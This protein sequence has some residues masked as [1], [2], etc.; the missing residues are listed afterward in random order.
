MKPGSTPSRRVLVVGVPLLAVAAL[1]MLAAGPTV[2]RWF[3][4]DEDLPK[5]NGVGDSK[6]DASTVPEVV[7]MELYVRRNLDDE[8]IESYDVVTEGEEQ[9]I[10]S[11]NPL[12]PED[13]LRLYAEFNQPSCWYLVQFDPAG[14]YAVLAKSHV[15]QTQ[16]QFPEQDRAGFNPDD[17]RGINALLLIAANPPPEDVDQFLRERLGDRVEVVDQL[18]DQWARLRAGM[19]TRESDAQLPR[20]FLNQIES[21]LPTE[22]KTIHALFLKTR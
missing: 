21:K 3:A 18:P 20:E 14:Q 1:T 22:H 2:R 16:M 4:V 10:P 9:A 6:D 12:R 7:K 8:Q 19:Q 15:P 17:P 11:L 5:R 13:D